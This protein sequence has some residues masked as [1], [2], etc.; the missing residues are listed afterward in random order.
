MKFRFAPIFLVASLAALP[1]AAQTIAA[2]DDFW[3]TP[4]NGATKIKV[5][6]GDVE[7]LCGLPPASG[8]N[9]NIVLRGIPAAGSDYDTVVRRLNTVTLSTT[10]TASI[11]I[12]VIRL[13]LASIAPQ[14]TPCGPLDWKVKLS[15][16]QVVTKMDLIRTSTSPVGGVFAADIAVN[17]ELIAT[18]AG[19]TSYVGSLFYNLLL[20]DPRNGTPWSLDGRQF[21]AGM[22]TADNCVDVLRTK[23]LDYSP[24]SDHFYFISDMI[25][26]GE[27]RKQT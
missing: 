6:A 4:P 5:K 17:V 24:D 13:D 25:A 9:H 10:G 19:S 20:P 8:W 22:T 1:A 27:C 26:K 18:K 12:R 21:R 3:V 15:G 16:P 14:L 23:L 7:A 2:G 11:P